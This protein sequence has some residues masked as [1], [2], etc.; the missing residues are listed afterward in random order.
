MNSKIF[1]FSVGPEGK[2]FP[3][4]SGAVTNLSPYFERL[5]NGPMLEAQNGKVIWDDIDIDTFLAFAEFAYTK[6]YHAWN[7]G[8]DER[9]GAD[10]AED[11]A[12]EEQPTSRGNQEQRKR[13]RVNYPYLY[14]CQGTPIP[15]CDRYSG[16]DIR[17][18]RSALAADEK[19]EDNN[20]RSR[21]I[22]YSP[23]GFLLSHLHVYG[24]ARRYCIE[25]LQDNVIDQLRWVF[26]NW[27][28][29]YDSVSALVKLIR[30]AFKVTVEG[31]PIRELLF[32]FGTC[33]FEWLMI[34][35]EWKKLLTENGEFSAIL[36]KIST[37]RR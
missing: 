35:P 24:L 4:H 25:T 22:R 10:D 30:A 7:A 9:S 3:I 31:D 36:H 18:C 11:L 19:G 17:R 37:S 5:I 1:I 16:F 34:H 14:A 6:E 32:L 8:D 12:S 28:C 27:E 2:E 15:E 26:L 33:V 23:F 21:N 20:K 13:F 29:H